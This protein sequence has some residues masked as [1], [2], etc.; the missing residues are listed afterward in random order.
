M[1]IQTRVA[2]AEMWLRDDLKNIYAL[3]FL[4]AMSNVGWHV[5]QKFVI[6]VP[7]Q[8]SLVTS[9]NTLLSGLSLRGFL[10]HQGTKT[11]WAMAFPRI[12]C[13]TTTA[14]VQSFACLHGFFLSH[15]LSPVHRRQKQPQR[16]RRDARSSGRSQRVAAASR[17]SERSARRAGPREARFVH[18]VD[19]ARQSHAMVFAW[20]NP[21]NHQAII[22]AVDGG[23]SEEQG[24]KSRSKRGSLCTLARQ[25][26]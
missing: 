5:T 21:C 1:E 16:L 18:F 26:H 7:D 23:E 17:R 12:N 3:L 8:A 11:T 24:K 20:W 14:T 15:L 25:S 19:L 9:V 13:R 6:L 2:P 22:G 10:S 4:L